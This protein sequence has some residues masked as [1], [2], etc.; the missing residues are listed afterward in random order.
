MKLYLI[1]IPIA[2]I[3]V[4]VFF[5]ILFKKSEKLP[6]FSTTIKL[7][8]SPDLPVGF[9]YKCQWIV[10]KSNDFYK[11]LSIL[12]FDEN[13]SSNWKSGIESA[14]SGN[15]FVSPP[16]NGWIFI[17]NSIMPFIDTR[18]K[19]NPINLVKI[20]SKE[21][22]ESYYFGTHRIV[23]YH[24]WIKAKNGNIIRAYA[25][26]GETGNILIDQGELTKE[27]INNNMYFSKL[28]GVNAEY[29]NEEDVLKISSDWS[30]SSQLDGKYSE[31]GVGVVGIYKKK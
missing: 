25:Y 27:E 13:Y 31:K 28:T 29:P 8:T 30:I 15:Y 18:E 3:I 11:L 26:L 7:D 21:F 19:D 10:V 6:S 20:L 22:G 14:Y 4:V 9:G 17:V 5:F 24:S 1:F 23:D 12:N 2:L 16:I